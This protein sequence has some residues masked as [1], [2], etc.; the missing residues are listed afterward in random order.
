MHVHFPHSLASS[1]L[2]CESVSTE[3]T[4]V[5][6]DALKQHRSRS[7]TELRRSEVLAL[8]RVQQAAAVTLRRKQAL[9]TWAL[10]K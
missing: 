10:R 8:A 6:D 7:A 5:G 1:P 4:A 2:T 3:R 9:G